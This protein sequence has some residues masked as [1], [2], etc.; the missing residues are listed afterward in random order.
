M[1]RGKSLSDLRRRRSWKR[2][3]FE[4]EGRYPARSR[5]GSEEER[6][7]MEKGR[8]TAKGRG[9]EGVPGERR[10]GSKRMERAA[11]GKGRRE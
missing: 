5:I 3:A 1:M 6:K 11:L 9:V 4:E 7:G 2:R 8:T 10:R